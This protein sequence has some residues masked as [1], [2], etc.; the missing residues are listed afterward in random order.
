MAT[1]QELRT[2][3]RTKLRDGPVRQ[4][5]SSKLKKFGEL[6]ISDYGIKESDTF[7]VKLEE[8]AK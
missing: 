3:L 6:L 8:D 5:V 4:Q 7:F 2:Q 1:N